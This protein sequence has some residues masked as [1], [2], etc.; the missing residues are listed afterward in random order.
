MAEQP[1]RAREDESEA[2]ESVS[3]GDGT[4]LLG[5][6]IDIIDEQLF[7]EGLTFKEN[8]NWEEFGEELRDLMFRYYDDEGEDDDYDP[9][10]PA[11]DEE[12]EEDISSTAE[13]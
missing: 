11:D 12:E 3:L 8:M 7:G 9:A 2:S 1:K 13:K 6:V 10:A 5:R 4:Q